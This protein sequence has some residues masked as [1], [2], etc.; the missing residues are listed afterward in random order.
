MKLSLKRAAYLTYFVALAM[1]FA[2]LYYGSYYYALK[3]MTSDNIITKDKLQEDNPAVDYMNR[4]QDLNEV[5]AEQDHIITKNTNYVEEF[6]N[7]DTDELQKKASGPPVEVL[8]YNRQQLI[9]YLTTYMSKN[10][11]ETLVNIQLVSFSADSVVVRKTIR[12]IEKTYNYYVIVENDM[13]SVYK[14]DKKTKYFDTG[15]SLSEVEER[16]RQ[17]LEDGFYVEDI[18]ELYNYLESITS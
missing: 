15:I 9:D 5:N 8:G 18:R 2:V 1:T 16:E 12:T 17:K 3:Y 7:I 13:I 14:A 11:D 4:E 6:Y 10:K